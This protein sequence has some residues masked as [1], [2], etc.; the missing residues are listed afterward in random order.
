MKNCILST[1][2]HVWHVP[3]TMVCDPGERS[4][5]RAPR[6]RYGSSQHHGLPDHGQGYKRGQKYVDSTL[7]KVLYKCQSYHVENV[8][9]MQTLYG[10]GL[11]DRESFVT[12]SYCLYNIW[13]YLYKKNIIES[14]VIKEL[15]EIRVA[16]KCVATLHNVVITT[17]RTL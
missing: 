1:E 11:G 7:F 3:G 15:K 2:L 5:Y 13:Q 14:F 10:T 17:I 4:T 12:F 8:I 6:C 9:H 16:N